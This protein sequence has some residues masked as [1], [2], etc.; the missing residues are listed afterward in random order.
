MSDAPRDHQWWADYYAE[1]LTA[2]RARVTELELA[3]LLAIEAHAIAVRNTRNETLED[4]AVLATTMI[5]A[6][7]REIAA[8]VR[9]LKSA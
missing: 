2:S 9:A 7:R 6:G 8:A 1:A 3:E 5:G 4:A